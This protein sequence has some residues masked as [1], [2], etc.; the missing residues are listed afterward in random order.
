MTDDSRDVVRDVWRERIIPVFGPLWLL[1]PIGV[2]IVNF[3]GRLIGVRLGMSGSCIGRILLVVGLIVWALRAANILRR[4]PVEQRRIVTRSGGIL[5]LHLLGGAGFLLLL[6]PGIVPLEAAFGRAAIG[7]IL[8][9]PA[10]F[11]WSGLTSPS[12][13]LVLG[14]LR[15]RKGG[16]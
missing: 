15:S 12:R 14:L 9:V 10:W 6:G 11:G 2:W 8:I 3:G 4:V 16:A 1:L 5:L 13:R 7:A